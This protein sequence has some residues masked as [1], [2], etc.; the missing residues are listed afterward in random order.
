MAEQ[1]IPERELEKGREI[2]RRRRQ[3]GR[4]VEAGEA[5]LASQ[6]SFS[7]ENVVEWLKNA[8]LGLI[9]NWLPGV[10][11]ATIEKILNRLPKNHHP[12]GRHFAVAASQQLSELSYRQRVG[13]SLVV[14]RYE[15]KSG[16]SR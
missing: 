1:T 5:S 3:F 10:G 2:L 13:L 4:E 16:K 15:K 14:E 11:P 6:I 9:L 12:A 7:D 8:R